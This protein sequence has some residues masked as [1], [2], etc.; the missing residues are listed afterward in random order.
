MAGWCE[1]GCLAGRPMSVK[2]PHL[3]QPHFFHMSA[4]F[5][6]EQ[7][8]SHAC[9]NANEDGAQARRR[10]SVAAERWFPTAR[11]A[12]SGKGGVHQ[13][14]GERSARKVA[15]TKRSMVSEVLMLQPMVS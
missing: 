4:C 6:R 13:L 11:M 3:I 12:N 14:N 2:Q 7:G 15:S 9:R 10:C 8:I 1:V 5:V